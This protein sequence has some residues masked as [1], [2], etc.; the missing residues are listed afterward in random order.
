M[1]APMAKISKLDESVKDPDDDRLVKYYCQFFI[2]TPFVIKLRKQLLAQL[3]ASRA[4]VKQLE[5]SN[6]QLE[7]ARARINQLE[8]T[9]ARVKLFTQTEELLIIKRSE[10]DPMPVQLTVKKHVS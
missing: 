10:D 4:R 3:E 8:S 5:C 2:I 7:S 9:T 6:T 1:M